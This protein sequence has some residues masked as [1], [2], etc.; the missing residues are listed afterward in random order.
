MALAFL[1]AFYRGPFLRE[2]NRPLKVVLVDGE[3]YRKDNRIEYTDAYDALLRIPELL[4]AFDARLGP[5]GELGA[6]WR[7]ANAEMGSSRRQAA[8][9]ADPSRA[10]PRRRPSASS[11]AMGSALRTMTLILQGFLKGEAGGRYD[12][13]ANLS[14]ID[15]KANK[16]FLRSLDRAKDRCERAYSSSPSSPAS[17]SPRKSRREADAGPSI[18][19]AARDGL[20]AAFPGPA[21][22]RRREPIA[23]LSFASPRR[24]E[25]RRSR[26]APRIGRAS[27]ATSASTPRTRAPRALPYAQRRSFPRAT[28]SRG[29]RRPRRRRRLGGA[30]GI[31]LGDPRLAATVTVA[32]CM[33]I[34]L[35]DRGSGTFGVLHSGW[36]GTGILATAVDFLADRRGVEALFDSRHPRA[37]H[38]KLLLRGSGGAGGGVR[39]RIRRGPPRRREGSWFLDLRSANLSLAERA[40][41]GHVLSI[42]ACTSCDERLGSF[43]RQGAASF[44]RMMAVCGLD[45]SREPGSAEAGSRR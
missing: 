34:W 17:T 30:D 12:S 2:L 42:D 20:A 29:P 40:G 26:A 45:R 9:A 24:H 36:R 5:E 11:S 14:Y 44:T 1:D 18:P 35:L 22:L 37:G 15:G 19:A 32:D 28:T 10:A 31:L 8:Q 21:R 41:V 13:L 27:S 25:I 39:G 16:E 23:L 6:S 4:S 43:R 3:F 7:S 33:P 38:R